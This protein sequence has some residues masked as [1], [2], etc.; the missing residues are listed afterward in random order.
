M[1]TNLSLIKTYIRLGNLDDAILQLQ[2]MAQEHAPQFYNEVI[3]HSAGLSQ[4]RTDERKRIITPQDARREKAHIADALLQLADDIARGSPF[5]EAMRHPS[6]ANA[7]RGEEATPTEPLGPFVI[8]TTLS[9]EHFAVCR[10]L[11]CIDEKP[12][13]PEGR[14]NLHDWIAGEIQVRDS[15]AVH[16]VVVGKTGYKGALPASDAVGEAIRYWN[17]QFLFF[18]GIAGGLKENKVR[19]GHVVVPRTIYGYELGAIGVEGFVAKPEQTY[20]VDRGLLNRAKGFADRHPDWSACLDRSPDDSEPR[21]NSAPL[22]SG[23]KTIDDPT[24]EFFEQAMK[25]F[26]DAAAVDMESAGVAHAIS[27]AQQRGEKTRFAVIRAISDMP[28]PAAEGEVDT[29]RD[30]WKQYAADV[31]ATFTVA[32]IASGNLP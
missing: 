16:P 19:R 26:P 31:A 11:D 12:D 1:T 3:V 5:S 18:I 27:S 25:T 30:Q 28:R 24:S 21:V 7:K 17:P 23:D 29:E 8:L 22:A 32:F 10:L 4:I 9:E 13:I 20:Q 14:P 2:Q 15:Q 6:A